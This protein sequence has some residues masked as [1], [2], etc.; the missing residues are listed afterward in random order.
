MTFCRQC[1]NDSRSQSCGCTPAGDSKRS[2][3]LGDDE[4]ERIVSRTTDLTLEKAEASFEKRLDRT[5]AE[6]DGRIDDKVR[7][8]EERAEARRAAA[9]VIASDRH[10][11][12]AQEVRGLATRL[13]AQSTAGSALGGGSVAPSGR[14]TAPTD[15]R[16]FIA[17][18]MEVK[19]FIADWSDKEAT[20]LTQLQGEPM[21]QALYDSYVRG[22]SAVAGFRQES[23]LL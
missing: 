23:A 19:K 15:N 22:R 4:I 2:K 17:E 13:T 9:E 18:C 6:F 7:L 20:A 12:L 3:T 10:E 21:V 8:S 16:R 11:A 14:T 1:G 5:M